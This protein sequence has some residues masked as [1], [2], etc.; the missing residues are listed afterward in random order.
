VK[1][2]TASAVSASRMKSSSRELRRLRNASCD[3]CGLHKKA[4]HV[5]VM[6]EGAGRLPGFIV[7]EAP[8]RQED[9]A[10]RPFVGSAGRLLRK[11]LVKAGIRPSQV[12][13]TNAAKCFPAGTPSPSEIWTCSEK[14]LTAELQL[15]NPSWILALGASALIALLSDATIYGSITRIRGQVLPC[16]Y[17]S[18]LILPTFHPAY[19]LHQPSKLPEF[20]NDLSMF[21][22]LLEFDL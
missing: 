1:I 10:G 19:I 3:L 21:S 8:G 15:V 6:G 20:Q 9:A 13:I 17:G 22:T 4:S 2:V 16:R 18:A 12:Y 5:C 14:Y 11:E 7:G